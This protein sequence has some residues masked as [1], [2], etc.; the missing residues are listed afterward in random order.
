[1]EST[2]EQQN[3]VII[4][5]LGRNIFTERKIKEIIIHGKR[6]PEA[7]IKGYNACDGKNGVTQIARIVGVKHQSIIPILKQW[8]DFGIVYSIINPN[9]RKVYKNLFPIR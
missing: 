5:L 9:G 1:M 6:N 7:Y 2:V 3:N 8:E 4:S